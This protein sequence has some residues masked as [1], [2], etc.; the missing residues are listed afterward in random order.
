MIETE[1]AASPAA[2]MES[3]SSC[4]TRR[5]SLSSRRSRIWTIIEED[6]SPE[7]CTVGAGRGRQLGGALLSV[8][9]GDRFF[10]HLPPGIL[11]GDEADHDDEEV[12]AVE[13]E[14]QVVP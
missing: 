4:V 13:L 12:E 2:M 10:A 6:G 7:D 5:K 11:Q 14:P 8:E 9:R 3:P 1:P